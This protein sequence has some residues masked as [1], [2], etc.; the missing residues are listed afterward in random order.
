MQRVEIIGVNISVVN[1]ES[2][3]KYLFDN[4]EKARISNICAANV[5]ICSH[6]MK[7]YSIEEFKIIH[8]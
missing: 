1:F 7:I 6:S 2:A 8:S 3:L 5:C 4:L